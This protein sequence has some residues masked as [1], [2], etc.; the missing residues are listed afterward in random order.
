MMEENTK[1]KGKL[2]EQAGKKRRIRRTHQSGRVEDM[3]ERVGKG[4]GRKRKGEEEKRYKNDRAG[5]GQAG[6]NTGWE[7]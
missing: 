2:K 7:E 3:Q 5:E 1:R 6:K 4:K